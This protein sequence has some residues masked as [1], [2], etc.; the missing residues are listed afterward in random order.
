MLAVMS[1]DQ[2][3]DHHLFAQPH[4]VAVTDRIAKLPDRLS[5]QRK[6]GAK[7]WSQSLSCVVALP[8]HADS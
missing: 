2:D 6:I 4:Q 1:K 3:G 5:R 7:P 8:R